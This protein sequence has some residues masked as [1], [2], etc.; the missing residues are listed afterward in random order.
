MHY[1]LRSASRYII[2]YDPETVE[3][4]DNDG[5]SRRWRSVTTNVPHYKTFVLDVLDRVRTGKKPLA[6]LS[7]MVPVMG[8]IGDAYAKAG[9]P[10]FRPSPGSWIQPRHDG[11]DEE[12]SMS[13]GT[14][15]FIVSG[16]IRRRGGGVAAYRK[17]RLAR[18]AAEAGPPNNSIRLHIPVGFA[19]RLLQ[20]QVQLDVLHRPQPSLGGR[21]MFAPRGKTLGRLELDQRN[22]RICAACQ[23]TSTIGARWTTSAGAMTTYCRSSASSNPI[24]RGTKPIAVKTGRSR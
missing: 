11:R 23:R 8:L 20:P 21:K 3:A 19:K 1:A 18:P 7:D 6:S 13:E 15:D 12:T 17:S 4:L 9:R 10:A 16:R 5:D 2:A 14:Y 24:P 22:D